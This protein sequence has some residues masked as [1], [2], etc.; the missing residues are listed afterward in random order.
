MTVLVKENGPPY[1]PPSHQYPGL[2]GKLGPAGTQAHAASKAKVT[3]EFQKHGAQALPSL[4][5]RLLAD[6]KASV[7]QACSLQDTGSQQ[8]QTSLNLL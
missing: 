8:T 5:A 4:R 3:A 6:Q 7:S 1:N 2:Q